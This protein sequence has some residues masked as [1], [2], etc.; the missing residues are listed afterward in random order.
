[1]RGTRNAAR[2]RRLWVESLESRVTPTAM[3]VPPMPPHPAE[4]VLFVGPEMPRIT[5]PIEIRIEIEG[6]KAVPAKNLPSDAT[7]VAES[8]ATFSTSAIAAALR[9]AVNGT[10]QATPTVPRVESTPV[11][12]VETKPPT[13]ANYHATSVST[14]EIAALV[15]R[16][17]SAAE[18]APADSI[19][20]FV[21][22]AHAAYW[23]RPV[24]TQGD[25]AE[26]ARGDAAPTVPEVA[27]IEP[28]ASPGAPPVTESS[29]VPGNACPA[30]QTSADSV[31]PAPKEAKTSST[32]WAGLFFL[33]WLKKPK[34]KKSA[35]K[36]RGSKRITFWSRCFRV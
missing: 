33:G 21:G 1:M 20:S 30:A 19:F 8:M 4:V 35:S 18:P 28:M 11:F 12:P 27:P 6:E 32:S 17:G 2:P 29:E 13:E 34:Q 31:A 9:Q 7:V 25:A 23:Q 16:L 36:R 24:V 10:T 3:P 26:A 14:E 5:L 15:A 22:P